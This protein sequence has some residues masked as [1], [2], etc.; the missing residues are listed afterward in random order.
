MT[1][2]EWEIHCNPEG[3]AANIVADWK[4]EREER[5][6][7][8]K[9]LSELIAKTVRETFEKME[10]LREQR[11]KLIGALVKAAIPLE[12]IN[13][14]VKWELADSIKWDIQEA[15]DCIRAV[16]PEVKGKELPKFKDIIGLFVDKPEE[17][18][19]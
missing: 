18:K 11:E 16:L 1:F 19:E 14:S 17:V 9:E 13:M 6:R 12:A 15:I 10:S 4:A 2:E 7:K 8:E 5:Y 3:T